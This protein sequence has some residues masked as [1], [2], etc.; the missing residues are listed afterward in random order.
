MSK[1]FR[2]K[3]DEAD[4]EKDEL[5]LLSELQPEVEAELQRLDALPVSAL[6]AEVLNKAFQAEYE[7][8]SGMKEVG[9]VIDAM[10]PPHGEYSGPFY[11]WPRPSTAEY[12]LR[13]LVREGLQVL[14]HARLLMPKG[15]STNGNWYHS[16][17]VT[18]RLGRAAM[19]D[20]SVEQ[21]LSSVA[22]SD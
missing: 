20:G 11:K 1:L 3:A 21:V 19:A 14:E 2:S 6:A 13:D 17:Y 12:R 22:P 16:G 5:P 10:L 15:Y 4:G 7:P 9:D 18:T 8:D